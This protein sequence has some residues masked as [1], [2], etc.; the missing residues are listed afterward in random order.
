M[1]VITVVSPDKITQSMFADFYKASNQSTSVV[2]TLEINSLFSPE[3]QNHALSEAIDHIKGKANEDSAII[4]IKY[5]TKAKSNIL[6][7]KDIED[8]S[9]TVIKFDLFSTHP[10][11]LKEPEVDS[12]KDFF[13]V[14]REHID[15]LN[16]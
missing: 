7:N 12:L 1:K 2:I 8:A 15:M 13:Q 11:I 5:R 3:V 16:S 9:N 14:W 10:E 6:I 4:L